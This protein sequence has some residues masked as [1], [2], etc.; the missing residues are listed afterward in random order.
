LGNHFASGF[1]RM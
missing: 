1:W